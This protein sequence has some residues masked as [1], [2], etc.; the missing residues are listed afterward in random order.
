M[1]FSQ[2]FNFFHLL[3][4]SRSIF[5]KF[6]PKIEKKRLKWKSLAHADKFISVFRLEAF[7]LSENTHKKKLCT[8]EFKFDVGFVH[9]GRHETVTKL[10]DCFLVCFSNGFA[11]FT[12]ICVMS[13]SFVMLDIVYMTVVIS[14]CVQCFLLIFFV[15]GLAEKVREKKYSL[16]RAM[17]VCF[18]FARFLCSSERKLWCGL[19]NYIFFWS[20]QKEIN[21][22]SVFLS[23]IFSPQ[24]TFEIQG[25]IKF[26]NQKPGTA[27]SIVM[28]NFGTMAIL[29]EYLCFFLTWQHDRLQR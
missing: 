8:K 10:T 2:R 11:R 27:L 7:S 28:V 12:L 25:H 6:A 24:E 17:K 18:G 29:G 14:Y 19:V 21:R 3:F 5:L 15:E 23:N 16:T 4:P 9:N 1:S 22:S 13:L 20:R 26:L